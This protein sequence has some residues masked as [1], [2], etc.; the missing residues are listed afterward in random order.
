MRNAFWP[1]VL[2][3]AMLASVA[4]PR[5]MHLH[6]ANGVRAS[7]DAH[8]HGDADEPLLHT[9]ASPHHHEDPAPE[10][11]E[12]EDVLGMVGGI[13]TVAAPY[14]PDPVAEAVQPVVPPPPVSVHRPLTIRQ[15]PSHAPPPHAAVGSRAPPPAFS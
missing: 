5:Q 11:G 2:T 8:H 10:Q 15:P 6:V 1:A 3:L 4:M 13:L 7:H 9:H 12:P 14:T